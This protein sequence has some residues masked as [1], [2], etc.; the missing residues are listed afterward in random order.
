M[1][2]PSPR[3]SIL[4]PTTGRA[5]LV[6][7]A[8]AS[9]LAQRFQNF[10]VII[11]DSKRSDATRR[12]AEEPRDSRIR[13]VRTP[14]G[15]GAFI[16]WDFA[17]TQ[18]RGEYLLWLDDDNYLLPFAL[19]VLD[20]A[21]RRSGADIITASHIYYYDA[22]NPRRFL[23]NCFGIV[24]FRGGEHRIDLREAVRRLFGFTRGGAAPWPRFHYSELA[25]SRAV[26]ERVRSR[27]GFVLFTNGHYTHSM[28]PI[29]F[30]FA[31]SCFFI[32]WPIVIV[33]RLGISMSQNWSTAARARFAKDPFLP[34]LSPVRAYTRINI[35]LENYLRVKEL[36]PDLLGDIP[37]NLERFAEIH[38]GELAY[39][40]TGLRTAI[41]N[42]K[43]MFALLRRLKPEARKR[44]HA[45]AM[46]LAM[47]VPFIYAGRRLGLHTLSRA[48]RGSSAVRH[49][50]R[51]SAVEK[52]QGVKEFMIPFKKEDRIDSIAAF[53]LKARD[54]LLR[55]IGLD[56]ERHPYAQNAESA[57]HTHGQA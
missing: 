21:I 11:A 36:L 6:R 15:G 20:H 52:L 4:I 51:L 47:S 28:Q 53:G 41:R 34:R 5:E 14:E 29:L 55:E 49:E 18:A 56:I 24:P 16:P 45:S 50:E 42:W 26:T 40:D 22:T 7:T 46:R 38:L 19:E 35:V 2:M 12:V 3:F 23:R 25:V 48:V 37:V 8:L 17:P 44:L 33:G 30:S 31:R 13:Y 1:R 57:A 9:V 39:L 43:E 27:L 54:I 10:E 32:D